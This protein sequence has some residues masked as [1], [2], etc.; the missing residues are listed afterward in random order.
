M[1]NYV[2][3]EWV[4]EQNQIFSSVVRQLNGFEVFLDDSGSFEIWGRF[5]NIS[6][7]QTGT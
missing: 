2:Q 1:K 6:N 4:K 5:L 3:I 7:T